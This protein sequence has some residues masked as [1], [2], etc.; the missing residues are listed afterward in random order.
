MNRSKPLALV[1]G[2]TSGIGKAI[3]FALADAGHEVIA[4]GRSTATLDQMQSRK[5]VRPLALDLIAPAMAT[6]RP[7]S[8]H[9]TKF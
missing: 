6:S 7:P 9:P 2:A 4:L 3:A 5:G 1:T 8:T